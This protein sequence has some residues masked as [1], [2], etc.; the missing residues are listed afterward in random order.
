[1]WIEKKH[2]SSNCYTCHLCCKFDLKNPQTLLICEYVLFHSIHHGTWVVGN[3]VYID[4]Y[5]Y[6]YLWL[7]VTHAF[8]I[9]YHSRCH[10]TPATQSP[11]IICQRCHLYCGLLSCTAVSTGFEPSFP[12]KRVS[13]YQIYTGWQCILIY[14]MLKCLFCFRGL[15]M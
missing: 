10:V 7:D 12:Q 4:R 14:A 1:M 9:V 3:P 6:L 8:S 13:M 2:L 15:D 11:P 5:I